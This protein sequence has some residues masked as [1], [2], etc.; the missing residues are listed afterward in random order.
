MRR[1]KWV[2]L[3]VVIVLVGVRCSGEAIPTGVVAPQ[4]GKEAVATLS[5]T[6][7]SSSPENVIPM[8]GFEGSEI[9][10]VGERTLLNVK[11]WGTYPISEL[12]LEIRISLDSLQINTPAGLTN[13][14]VIPENF[15]QSAEIKR[16]EVDAEGILHYQVSGLGESMIPNGVLLIIPLI[17]RQAGIGLV[18]PLEA[19]VTTVNG[20][21]IPV[22]IASAW[23]LEIQNSSA[24]APTRYPLLWMA[25]LVPGCLSSTAP[26]IW[27]RATAEFID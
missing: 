4:N 20:E 8:I 5:P 15:P 10:H 24:A 3:I 17:P 2:W 27:R 13:Q 18:E 1:I 23:L 6:L 25:K 7:T 19:R 12:T 22:Q 21:P 11:I 9:V 14:V 16:N 26:G